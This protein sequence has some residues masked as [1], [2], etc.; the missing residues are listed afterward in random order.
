MGNCLAMLL[1]MF[2]VAAL[3]ITFGCWRCGG[4]FELLVH[5][6]DFVMDRR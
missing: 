5:V 6:V 1:V 3:A 2:S 4:P